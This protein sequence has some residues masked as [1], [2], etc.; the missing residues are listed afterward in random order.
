MKLTE[1][2]KLTKSQVRPILKMTFP[3]YRGRTFRLEFRREYRPG[4]YWSGGTKTYFKV[5]RFEEEGI[6]LAEAPSEM[7]N[8]YRA[9]AHEK[10][11]IRENWM[12][13]ERVYFCGKDMGIV[14]IL[15]PDC[16]WVPKL[17]GE[18]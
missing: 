6:R 9:A 7:Q 13:V 15:H 10:F 1:T 11:G 18:R 17:L 5:L 2:V 16:P 4:C 14:I 8:P 12:I 3:E